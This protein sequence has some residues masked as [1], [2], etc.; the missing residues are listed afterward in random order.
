MTFSSE[1]CPTFLSLGRYA[2]LIGLDP[3]RFF[4]GVTSLRGVNQCS[5]LWSQF[6]WQD[7]GKVSREELR[8]AI[9]Q[10]EDDITATVG[11][12]PA[13][14][15][16]TEVVSYPQFYQKEYRGVSGF[17]SNT[18]NH[19][20]GVTSKKYVISG[21]V[22]ATTAIDPREITRGTDIDTTGDGFT[23]TA[24]FTVTNLTFTD[25]CELKAYFKVY[26]DID[27]DNCRTDPASE[28]VDD[29][30][31]IT[32]IRAKLS[33]T[34]ATVYI[35]V[36]LLF[37][38]QLQRRINAGEI[39][40]DDFANSYVDT[41][42]FYRVYNDPT[43]QVSFLWTTESSCEDYSCAWAVQSGC[44]R[45]WDSR[46]GI[47]S[48]SPGTY[49]STTGFFTGSCFTQN[50]EPDKMMLYYYSG[51]RSENNRNCD[52]LN[53]NLARIIAMLASARLNKPVCTCESP[54]RLIER[55]QEEVTMSN[56]SRSY[57][58]S[59]ADLE[60]PFGTKYGELLAYKAL[61]NFGT[62]VGKNIRA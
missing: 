38:P 59:V 62:K 29:Y 51:M 57:N 1:F 41:V 4:G 40:A 8:Q 20:T 32:P 6:S 2:N 49:D 18:F 22:R 53:N 13:P 45:V 11:Y 48:V 43:S 5:D 58:L 30:W 35:P 10:A 56:A 9:K 31:E 19:K 37:K 50:R 61:K 33:G 25:I 34:T 55:W 7:S 39:D 46:R 52:E 44:M 24:V 26:D 54:A 47:V 12:F 23:D 16:H 28:G 27:A 14:Y 60:C 15:W 17:Q 21:G 36:Y 3:L 42:E